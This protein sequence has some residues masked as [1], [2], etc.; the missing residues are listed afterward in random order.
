MIQ[1][2]CCSRT[3]G[4]V[5]VKRLRVT[6][7]QSGALMQSDSFCQTLTGTLPTVQLFVTALTGVGI[8]CYSRDG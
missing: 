5:S 3:Q 8:W 7:C 2:S 4:V 6:S 1:M